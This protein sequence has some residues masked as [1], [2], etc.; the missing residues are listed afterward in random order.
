MKRFPHR[1]G[2]RAGNSYYRDDDRRDYR[3]NNCR[4]R[5]ERARAF[6]PAWRLG[7][8]M[9]PAIERSMLIGRR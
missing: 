3:Y 9:E 6:R 4:A 2:Y 5:E 8:Y 1:C 7:H